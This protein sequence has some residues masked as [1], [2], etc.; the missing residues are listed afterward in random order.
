MAT[1]KLDAAPDKDRALNPPFQPV[2]IGFHRRGIFRS[3]LWLVRRLTGLWKQKGTQT[4]LRDAIQDVRRLF[5]EHF[6]KRKFR[7]DVPGPFRRPRPES[8]WQ[9]YSALSDK[10]EGVRKTQRAKV[11]PKQPSLVS[12]RQ[13]QLASQ[14]LSLRFGPSNRPDVSIIIPVFNNEK[15][16]IECLTSIA[17]NTHDSSYEIIVI[18]DASASTTQELLSRVRSIQY[19][20]N[21]KNL[22]FLRSCNR[23]AEHARGQFLLFLNND[24]QVLE[25]WLNALLETFSS[26]KNVGAVGPKVLFPDGRLQECGARINY[27]ATSQLIGLFDD[28]E[29]PKYNIIREVDYVSGCC[30]MVPKALFEEVGRFDVTFAPAYCEDVD[31]C[32]KLRARGFRIFFN[33]RSTIV[34]HLSATTSGTLESSYKQSLVIR[35]QQRLSQKW[36]TQIDG[37]NRV[38]VIA[39]YLPQYHPIPEN[40]LWWGKGFTEWT[41]V[42][43]A[44]RNFVGHYQPRLPADLGFYDLRVGEVMEQQAELARRYGIHGF[45]FYYYWFNGKRLL[46]L[47]IERLLESNTPDI[48]FCLCWANENWS[49]RWDGGNGQ[50]LMAQNHSEDDDRAVIKDLIRYLRHPN[51]IRIHGRPLL[52]V[53]RVDLFPDVSRTTATWREICHQERLG[54]IYLAMVNSFDFS[55][56][57]I[58]PRKLGFDAAVEFPPHNRLTPIKTPGKLLNPDYLGRVYDYRE[59]VMKHLEGEPTGYVLFRSV[60]PS[61]DNTARRQNDSAILVHGSPGAYR[62]WLESA[63]KL[64]REQNFGDER[65]VFIAAWNEW[66]EGNYLEPDDRFGHEFLEAT[67]DALERD[68][69]TSG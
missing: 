66:A 6:E 50:V 25:G 37:L 41:N 36:Q 1:T 58:D 49:Q 39:F 43:K 61:W 56:R 54:D 18:D 67:R 12:L 17:S 29:L 26:Y 2:R 22:G 27:D 53:Y 51:Y 32:F 45:C 69:W 28:P 13:E 8:N 7:F 20:R 33:P 19:I 59:G 57:P 63:I 60:M 62:A 16:T 3:P 23:G 30:L 10:I 42:V 9:A 55:W 52:L 46:E 24:T 68:L 65:I 47:P 31:L 11:H 48:P 5:L 64:S 35:G 14:A 15:L 40:D 38:R 4:F 44:R 21:P 34:H